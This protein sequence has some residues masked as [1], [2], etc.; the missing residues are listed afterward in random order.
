MMIPGI[1]ALGATA[2]L[3]AVGTGRQF[4]KTRDLA[5]WLG[6]V[7]IHVLGRNEGAGRWMT[8]DEAIEEANMRLAECEPER[9]AFLQVRASNHVTGG[10]SSHRRRAE[11]H[12]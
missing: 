1:G 3:A 10:R 9:L 11:A 7:A 4:Q 2:I 8:I 5:A 12:S 6:L